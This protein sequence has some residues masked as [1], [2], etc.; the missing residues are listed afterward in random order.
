MTN[1]VQGAISITDSGSIFSLVVT[2]DW[3][4]AKVARFIIRFLWIPLAAAA[5]VAFTPFVTSRSRPISHTLS[6]I[7]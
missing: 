3:S 5:Q 4:I 1:L 6:S 2:R 7:H